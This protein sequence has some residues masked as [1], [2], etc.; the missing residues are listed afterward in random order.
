MDDFVV[1][2]IGFPTLVS[3]RGQSAIYVEDEVKNLRIAGLLLEAGTE[4]SLSPK[5]NKSSTLPLLQWGSRASGVHS[6]ISKP[7]INGYDESVLSDIF[8]RVGAFNYSTSFI[9][10]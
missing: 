1:L 8:T 3:S 4:V 9:T 10:S 5:T 2:G 7:K 6:P